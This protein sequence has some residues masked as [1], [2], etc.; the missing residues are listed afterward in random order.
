[1]APRRDLRD[2][3]RTGAVRRLT[4]RSPRRDPGRRILAILVMFAISGVMLTRQ[5]V[6]LQVV[7]AKALVEQGSEQRLRSVELPARRG[8][9]FDRDGKQLVVSVGAKTVYADPGMVEQP[10]ATAEALAGVLHLPA[11]QIESK[12]RANTRFVYL[13]RRVD[14]ATADA[15]QALGRQGIGTIDEP[16]RV[17]S[18]GELGSQLL[19][20]V[21]ADG[22]GMAGVEQQ[23]DAELRGTP[24]L[25][26]AERD[27]AGR[28][29]PQGMRSY[30]APEPGQDVMLTIDR[31]LQF[32]TERE[33]AQ[34]VKDSNAKGGMAFVLDPRNGEILALANNPSF[35]PNNYA[36]ASSRTW[37]NRA[38]TDVF[39]PGSANKV[40]TAAAALEEGVTNPD[41]VFVV[42]DRMSMCNQVFHDAHEHATQRLTFSEIISESSNVGTIQVAGRLGKERMDSYLRR[43]GYGKRTGVGLPGES[44]GLIPLPKNYWCT[45]MGSVPI[46]QGIAVTA[47]QIGQVYATLANGGVRIAPHLLKAVVDERGNVH[48]AAEPAAERVI[49]AAT[50]A[51]LSV[52]LQKAVDDGTGTSASVP[53][54]SVAGKTGTARKP[55]EGQRGY[56]DAYVASFVGFLPVEA[57][58][59]VVGVILDE[60]VP[61]FGGVVSA[62]VFSRIASIAAA[63]LGIAPASP[64][65][66]GSPL[67]RL[68]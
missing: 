3:G 53:G 54:L 23:Y 27:P 4:R 55:L 56:S 24:G 17:Y 48:A 38:V 50:A 32:V 39:E 36:A 57:P 45:S 59:L 52:I 46:G 34:G 51:R 37:R 67:R 22:K 14:R 20:F 63:R 11:A 35:D 5:L 25:M 28:A 2:N 62:P 44:A 15:V 65:P 29:I 18:D 66:S 13:A 9:I 12:L 42:P 31:Y 19:G 8:R 30:R 26:V 60:P 1:M 21:G 49:S 41:E 33:L 16:K 6:Q 64:A 7:Q 58:R 68:P 61:I 40:I 10:R 43:F 47:L